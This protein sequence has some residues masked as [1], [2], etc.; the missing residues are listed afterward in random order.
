MTNTLE[1]RSASCAWEIR[2]AGDGVV[3]LRG[4]AA[5]FDSESHG[6]VVRRSAFNKT[7]A[8]GADVRFLINHEGLPLARTKSQTMRLSVDNVGLRMEI[9][10]LDTSSPMVQ[11]LLS[12]IKRGDLDQMSFAFMAVRDNYTADGVRELTEV[13]L[14]D[15]SAV[16]YPWYE[17]TSVGMKSDDMVLVEARAAE[18]MVDEVEPLEP[19]APEPDEGTPAEESRDCVEALKVAL[20][21]TMTVYRI[22]HGLHWNT[23]GGEFGTFA[24]WHGLFGEIY[25]AHYEAIDPTAENILKCGYDAP[26]AQADIDAL[27]TI[28]DPDVATDDPADM[29]SVL[30]RINDALLV[31]L[32]AAFAAATESNEQGVANFI[33]D[34]IDETQKWS[35]Q[36]RASLGIQTKRETPTTPNRRALALDDLR[37]LISRG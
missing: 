3:G 1:R 22:A 21:D 37:R 19:G 10:S 6:E 18:D 26:F 31:T 14:V 13:K 15:V 8:D 30:L 33:A 9:D 16:T 17:Q 2:E 29:A 35:W 5:V 25:S 23:K 4:Y 34:R 36:L 24:Q 32:N 7:L 20:A 11:S 12:A 27:R 28:A